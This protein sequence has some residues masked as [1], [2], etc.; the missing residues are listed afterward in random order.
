MFIAMGFIGMFCN[1]VLYV[2]GV[3]YTTADVASMFQ[4][5]IPVWTCIVAVLARI[6]KVPKLNTKNGV[7][8]FLG[9]LLAVAGAIIMTVGKNT[10]K[11]KQTPTSPYQ[12]VGYFALIGNTMSMAVYVVIQRKYI[13]NVPTSRWLNRPI[14]VTAW[15]YLFGFISMALASLYYV[16]KPE[17]FQSVSVHIVYPLIYAVFIASALCYMLITWCNMQISSTVVTASWPLQVFF[18]VI[19]AYFVLG[20][21]VS[22]LEIC[23]GML[24]IIALLAVV[25]SNYTETKMNS[26][27]PDKRRLLNVDSENYD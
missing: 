23:G 19:L 4:P 1:Q 8:K 16:N 18:C 9:I 22:P 17:K 10:S 11:G 24:I 15:A 6:E 20:E 25:W 3:Y 21:I 7:A 13:F 26:E 5:V 14:A 2:L 27:D 12:T